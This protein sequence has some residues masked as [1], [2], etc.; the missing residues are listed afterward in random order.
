MKIIILG[1]GA[2]GSLYGAKLSKLYDV[3]LV[4]R[5]QHV[6]KINKDGLKIVGIEQ[7]V[8]KLKAVTEIREIDDNTLILL[9]TKVHDSKE[10]IENI[11]NLIKKDTIVLC[12]QNGLYSEDIVKEIVGNKC[13]VIRGITAVGVTFI[14]PG[15]VQFSNLS[16]TTIEKSPVSQELA[17]NFYKCHLKA[18]V[19]ENLKQDIWKKLIVNCMLNPVTAIFRIDNGES[20]DEKLNPLK[21]AISDECLKVA[22]KDGVKFDFDF[23]ETANKNLEGSRN[24]S[25]MF[26]DLVKGRKTEIDYL[27]GAVVELGK[28]YGIKCPVNEG[29]VLIIKGMENSK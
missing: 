26:Q 13:L 24:M 28:K 16:Y 20:A 6:D 11:K 12:L 19:S 7:N 5:R 10:A 17:N 15:I 22:E 25:S 23:V 18:N 8:Y 4:G 9:T 21:K 1:A 29:L 14:E 27:N 2:I 3:T